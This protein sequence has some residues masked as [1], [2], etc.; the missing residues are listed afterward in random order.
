VLNFNLKTGKSLIWKDF[1]TDQKALEILAEKEFK[2]AR[3]LPLNANLM[4]EGFF[5]EG[6]FTLPKNFELQ[7]EG[8]Y[9]WYNPFEAAA[10]ALGPTDFTISYSELGKLV[11]KEVLF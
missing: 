5:W 3:E 9:F 1:I 4:E 6:A 2:K 11:K 10:Y 7:E 8:I